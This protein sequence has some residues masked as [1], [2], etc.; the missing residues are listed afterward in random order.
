MNSTRLAAGSLVLASG[1]L[2]STGVIRA[3]QSGSAP[4][5]ATQ[6]AARF[7]VGVDAVRIDAV[8]TDRDGRTVPNLTANDFEVRQDGRLQRVTFAQYMPVASGAPA[9]AATAAVPAGTA[10]RH[11]GPLF[12]AAE[13]PAP[14]RP[15][16]IQRTLAVVVD[17]LGLSFESFQGMQRALHAFVDRELRPADLVAVVRT[18]GAGGG[19][20][21][22][23]TDHRVLHAVIDGLRWNGQSRNGAEPYDALNQWK[24]FSGGGP[25]GGAAGGGPPLMD[26]DDFA[27]VNQ[28]RRSS[29]AAGTLGALNLV[30]RGTRDL[31]GRKAIIL[32]SEGFQF[33][34][35]TDTRL[36]DS[37]VRAALDRVIDQATRAG[38]VIYSLDARG[39]Q[40]A[41]LLAS[42]N[43]KSKPDG[44]LMETEIRMHAGQR[45]AFNRDTQEGMAYLAEQTGGFAVLNSNDIA[46]GLGRITDDVRDYYVIGY[47]PTDGTFA[48]PGEKPSLHKI[49]I[50]AKQPGLHVKTRKEF[51]GVSDPP[52]IAGPSTPAQQ[53]IHAA[54][55]PFAATDIALRATTLPGYSPEKGTFVR[56][57]LH[58]DARPLTFVDSEDGKKTA[59]VDV[60][61]MVFDEDGTEVAHLTTGFSMGL[62]SEAA[63]AAVGDG[64]AYMLRIP[65]PHAGAYQVRFAVRDQHSGLTGSAGEFVEVSDVAG[66]AFALSG[67]V[68]R[69][70]DSRAAGQSNV[71]DDISVSPVQALGVYERGTRLSYAYEIYNAVTPVQAAT[72]IWRGSERILAVP[73][74]TLVPPPGNERRFAAAG[75]VRLGDK[76][77]AG[78]YVLQIAATKA[79]PQRKGRSSTAVQRVAFDVR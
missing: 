13:T 27:K 19:L 62:T 72:T 21:P 67:I 47:S 40:T 76:L 17:D 71:P 61:G 42:D 16:E 45:T 12:P 63:Q 32:V 28:L 53:L 41:G 78:R 5:Q 22:F 46:G 38:V 57:L 1:L 68:L 59:S 26:P 30:V 10:P 29:S 77:P 49:S 25:P 74:D 73:P 43:L 55:S 23:T 11:D 4:P 48:R 33:L 7:R 60:L 56:A 75:G 2:S 65:I 64:L 54:T 52:D 24:T 79:D 35:P 20:Q 14:V 8:V 9:I 44:E 37:R 15:D 58:I 34:D 39:L 51:L 36:P 69:S 70:E 6:D 31:P 18:G 50:K 3:G 66:G